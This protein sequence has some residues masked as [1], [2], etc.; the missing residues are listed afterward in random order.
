M[1]LSRTER[2]ILSNQFSMLERLSSNPDDVEFYKKAQNV[3]NNGYELHYRWLSEH[4]YDEPHTLSEEECREVID[5]LTMFDAIK[6]S[7]TRLTD[8]SGI[9]EHRAEFQGF[10]GNDETKQM[11][12][13]RFFC[14]EDGQPR[15][16]DLSKG[17]NFNSHFPILDRYRRMLTEWENSKDKY[18]LT[19]EDIIRITSV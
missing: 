10:S 2:W 1:K 8:T 6:Q 18:S 3:V 13:A 12:Y 16:A 14:T 7:Y 11:S 4:I 17:D 5:I 15:F 9:V 19:K